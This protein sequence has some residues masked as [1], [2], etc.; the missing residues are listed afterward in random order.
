MKN[1]L[2]I[3]SLVCGFFCKIHAQG[4]GSISGYDATSSALGKTSTAI[5]K[6]L[7]AVGKNPANILNVK[8]YWEVV[9]VFPLPSFNFRVGTDFITLKDYNYYFGGVTDAQNKKTG[10]YL[11]LDDKEKL[12]S[13]FEGGG[14]VFTD[15]SAQ[16]FSVLYKPNTSIGAF[17]FSIFDV[18][19]ASM[20]FPQDIIT[21]GL[22]GNDI[23][24]VFNFNDADC[25]A[26]WIRK[27]SFSYAKSF[28]DLVPKYMKE[29]SIGISLNIVSGFAYAGIN[30]VDV[31]TGTSFKNEIIGKSKFIAYSSFSK[32]LNVEYDFENVS[33]KKSYSFNLFPSP[34]GFG[35]GFDFG[36]N[37][38][39]NDVTRIALAVTDIGKIKW[40]ERVAEFSSDNDLFLDDITNKK[41]RDSLVDNLFGDGKFVGSIITDLPTALRFGFALQLDKPMNYSGKVLFGFDYNQGF[42]NQ[43]GNSKIARFSFGVEWFPPNWILG[44]RSGCTLGGYDKFG[45]AL[46][47]GIESG[48]L[49]FN[50]ALPE[51]QY[52]FTPD[53]AKKIAFACDSRW[54]F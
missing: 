8:K 7:F 40:T 47:L 25:S 37:L 15:L 53:K 31:T 17:A 6:G 46:G 27:Y 54:R 29:L 18:A 41:Q 22:Y 16:V 21:L 38:N 24:K 48:L 19:S 39:V 43:P 9:S 1:Y 26:W 2:I 3:L 49:E 35:F 20:N 12:K 5:S 11:S 28:P 51:F 52:L 30:E 34:A 13:I 32:S 42:N 4:G 23:S 33:E 14:L 36:F 50:F 45:W 10:R 44:F